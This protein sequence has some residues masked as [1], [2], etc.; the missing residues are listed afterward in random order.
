MFSYGRFFVIVAFV[1]LFFRAKSYRSIFIAVILT[2]LF[3]VALNMG[4]LLR[5]NPI[6][7]YRGNSIDFAIGSLQA[8]NYVAYFAVACTC[9]FVVS[10]SKAVT[11]GAKLFMAILILLALYQ[12]WLKCTRHANVLL[13][14]CLGVQAII[15]STSLRRRV[16]LGVVV[17]GVVSIMMWSPQ[18]VPARAGASRNWSTD[19]ISSVSLN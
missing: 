4:W 15:L 1:R 17:A 2:L 16:V 19:L 18:L 7:N 8:C 6:P 3:E 12:V 10:Y 14:C 9:L 13:I 11:A 5:V